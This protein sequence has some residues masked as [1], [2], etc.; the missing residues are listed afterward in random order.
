MSSPATAAF[1]SEWSPQRDKK[2]RN[3]SNE[4]RCRYSGQMFTFYIQLTLVICAVIFT[5]YFFSNFLSCLTMETILYLKTSL[6]FYMSTNYIIVIFTLIKKR[7]DTV[8]GTVQFRKK[9]NFT[10][11]HNI[12]FI[13]YLCPQIHKIIY[14]IIHS[15][16]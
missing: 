13:F 15:M 11:L 16:E 14:F 12:W 4:S 1:F 3:S 5:F 7:G 2:E 8:L 10:E 6:V 9:Q